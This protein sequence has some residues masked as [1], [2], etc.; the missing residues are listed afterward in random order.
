MTTP[1]ISRRKASRMQ[2]RMLAGASNADI[3]PGAPVNP[4]NLPDPSRKISKNAKL[5]IEVKNFDKAYKQLL[6]AVKATLGA[7]IS[8]SIAKKEENGYQYGVMI[9]RVPSKFFDTLFESLKEIG[10][11]KRQNI[12]SV[13]FTESY[14]DLEARLKTE[15]NYK[16]RLLDIMKTRA[17]NYEDV[18]DAY[19]RLS[20]VQKIIDR[21]KGKMKYINSVTEYSTITVSFNENERNRKGSFSKILKRFSEAFKEG[22]Y[23][24]LSILSFI[25]EYALSLSVLIALFILGYFITKKY[26]IKKKKT[27]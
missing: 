5:T 7:Y 2:K 8:S 11:T 12:T 25:I 10:E 13:D 17:R 14:Y 1:G 15:E 19:K 22:F 18:Q 21:I 3:S 6:A 4:D 20:D 26:I 9:I 27:E 16:T 24:T 23:N